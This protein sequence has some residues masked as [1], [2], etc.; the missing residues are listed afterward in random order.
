MSRADRM[1]KTTRRRSLRRGTAT[2]TALVVLALMALVAYLTISRIATGQWPAWADGGLAQVPSLTW[3]MPALIA[4]EAV[5]ILLGLVLLA[6]ALRP[7]VLRVAQVASP[8]SPA[9]RHTDVTLSRRGVARLAASRADEI[10]GV[11]SLST[12]ATGRRVTLKVDTRS[13]DAAGVRETVRAAVAERLAQAT[14]QPSPRVSVDVRSR[15]TS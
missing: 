15:T 9:V 1:V 5:L 3:M 4:A 7:G 11:D 10:D 2:V 6:K 13:A 8:A 12:T 14:L